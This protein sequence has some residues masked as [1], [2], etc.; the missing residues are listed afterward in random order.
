MSRPAAPACDNVMCPQMG[1]QITGG[2]SRVTMKRV[3][4]VRLGRSTGGQSKDLT[5]VQEPQAS[6][7]WPNKQCNIVAAHKG[8]RGHAG[9]WLAFIRTNDWWRIDSNR[10]NPTRENPFVGQMN[11]HNGTST[12]GYTLDVFFFN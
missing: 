1:R 4:V 3:T 8:V 11:P 6:A 7:L 2:T 12:N 5:P 9:H 10:A